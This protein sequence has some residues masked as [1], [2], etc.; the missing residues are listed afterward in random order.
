MAETGHWPPACGG[1]QE[2]R[3]SGITMHYQW[4][5]PR[6]PSGLTGLVGTD[7]FTTNNRERGTDGYW[8]GDKLLYNCYNEMMMEY[9]ATANIIFLLL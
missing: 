1:G 8:C 4:Q 6:G 9:R 3:L 7:I 2:Q 5:E